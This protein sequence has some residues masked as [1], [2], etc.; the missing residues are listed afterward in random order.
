MK[1]TRIAFVLLA[2]IGLSGCSMVDEKLSMLKSRRAF[3]QGNQAYANKEY[4]QAVDFY[5][6]A[7]ELD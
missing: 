6:T 1:T 4:A 7:L 2:A 3:K 5:N